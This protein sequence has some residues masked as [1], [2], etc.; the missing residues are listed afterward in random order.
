MISFKEAFG[1]G[2][3]EASI[4]TDKN[5]GGYFDM[6]NRSTKVGN[7]SLAQKTQA[8]TVKK[9]RLNMLLNENLK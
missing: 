5:L 6:N 7:T 9:D 4:G 3:S 2:H 8:N 1:D